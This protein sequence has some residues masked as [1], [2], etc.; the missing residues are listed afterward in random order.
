MTWLR[1]ASVG[2][3]LGVV[4]LATVGPGSRAYAAPNEEPAYEVLQS[5]P[6]FEVRRYEPTI[7]AQVTVEGD[8]SGAVTKAFRVLASYIFGGNAPRESIAMT[9]PVS[10]KP[11]GTSIAM[12]TP[13]SAVSADG[14]WIVSFTMPRQWTMQTL[15]VPNDPR[16][17]L[18]EVPAA[19]FAVRTFNGRATDSAVKTELDALRAEVEAAGL[20]I[21]GA[22]TVSQF[23][24]PW[25]LGPWRRN[26]VRW[27]IAP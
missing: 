10:A 9:T 18:V 15:P 23:N 12:T 5:A 7:E 14:S 24:P 17:T 25:I 2:A 1:V 20:T 3:L 6:G 26:E 13:V 16:V 27:P 21:D 19:A 8:Y 4:L 11:A 22:P